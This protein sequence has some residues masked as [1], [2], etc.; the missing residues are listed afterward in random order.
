MTRSRAV[1]VGAG[2]VLVVLAV[3]LVADTRG[4]ARPTVAPAPAPIRVVSF[5]GDGVGTGPGGQEL[6]QAMGP[7]NSRLTVAAGVR[8]VG[9][10]ASRDSSW[11]THVRLAGDAPS[12]EVE[13]VARSAARVT[14]TT[15][16]VEYMDTPTLSELIAASLR[17]MAELRAVPGVGDVW[18]E[19]STS[20]V[21]V[22]VAPGTT[23]PDEVLALATRLFSSERVSVRVAQV[24]TTQVVPLAQG[25]V[26][27][28]AGPRSL[29]V[30]A[31]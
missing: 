19:E 14:G 9:L 17:H 2:A 5:R 16:V 15:I 6:Q 26:G 28:Q 3:L 21:V 20:Q 10:F 1:A 8:M 7:F 18:A 30:E 4:P 31:H 12:T 25:R 24:D 13:R 11:S 23:D 22:D 29:R 27:V